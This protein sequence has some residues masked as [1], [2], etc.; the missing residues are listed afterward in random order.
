MEYATIVIIGIAVILIG[1][2]ITAHILH[3]NV[4]VQELKEF[5]ESLS[6]ARYATCEYVYTDPFIPALKDIYIVKEI[7]NGWVRLIQIKS[8][9]NPEPFFKT[10][11]ESYVDLPLKEAYKV[12]NLQI[13]E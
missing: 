6:K 11:E 7:K 8:I 13:I 10:E 1:I 2:L 3:N 12:L 9:E 4:N 5:E